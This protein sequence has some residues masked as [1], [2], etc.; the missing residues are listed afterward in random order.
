MSL[1]PSVVR[2]V[3]FLALRLTLLPF[4]L[5]EVFQRKKVTIITYHCPTPHVFD[6][7]LGTLTR[8]Y[9]II[10]L[11]V[12]VE[13]RQT[14]DF[15]ALPPKA[16][17]V[18]LDDGHRSTYGLKRVLER[19][20]VPVTIFLCSGLIDTRRKFWFLHEKTSSI[21]QQLKT[22]PDE[23]R[24][25]TLHRAGFEE[26][27]EFD[28]R[29]AL[30]TSEIKTLKADF[31]SHT[32]FHPILPRCSSERAE[33]EIR[34]SRFDLQGKLGH[35]VYALAYPNGEYS[36]RELRL[37]KS[38]GYKCALT[39]DPGFNTARTPLFRLRRI[40][41]PDDA[42]EHELVAR[43][44]GLWDKIKVAFDRPGS[45]I[46]SKTPFRLPTPNHC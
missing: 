24:I 42:N 30:S 10:P 29:Q 27:K 39:V 16:L 36:E 33:A 25:A 44:S 6:A 1:R 41:I 15:N 7:H 40:Y 43:T 19:H 13:A 14:R 4:V 2:K 3:A 21:V 11:S 8:I 35:E 18:T 32:V 9:N 26:T 22:V 28:E 38:A 20:N 46:I 34:G 5:R 17:I 12:Y 45:S 23:E 37:V 31:Q